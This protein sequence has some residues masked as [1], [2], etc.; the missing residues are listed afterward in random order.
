MDQRW[1][2]VESIF[3]RVVEADDERRAAILEEACAGDESLRVEVESLLARDRKAAN[4]METPAISLATGD[5]QSTAQSPTGARTSSAQSVELGQLVNHYRVVE[6]IGAGGMGVVYK[7]LDTRLD[8]AVALKFLPDELSHDPVAL[9]RFRREAKSASSLN[10]SNI[11]TIYDIGEYRGHS[12]IAMEFLDG[13]SLSAH[14]VG[15]PMDMD[16]VLPLAIE[17][18]DGLDAAHSAGIVHRD[19]KSANIFVT[20]RNHAK[21]LDFGLAKLL[22]RHAG[23]G[24]KDSGALTLTQTGTTLGT[25]SYMSP[26]QVRGKGVDAR[27]DLFSF[28]VVL[29]EMLTGRLPFAGEST[30]AIFDSILNR[31]PVPPIR[32]NPEIPIELEN[33]LGKCLEKD[34]D[35]RYQHASEIRTDLRRLKRLMESSGAILRPERLEP[36]SRFNMQLREIVAWALLI[37]CF[38]VVTWLLVL[39]TEQPHPSRRSFR[40]SL[41]PPRDSSFVQ[42]GFALSPNGRQVAFVASSVNGKNKLWLRA[43]TASSTQELNGTDGALFPFWS[44]DSRALGYFA[45]GKLKTIDIST[46]FVQIVCESAAAVGATWNSE[47]TIL[48]V[49]ANGGPMYRVRASGGT[50]EVVIKPA[51]GDG[52]RWPVF[53]PDNDHF[54]FFLARTPGS[55]ESK[56]A[57]TSGLYLGSLTSLTMKLLSTDIVNNVVVQAGRIY[58]VRDRSLLAQ[59]FDMAHMELTGKPEVIVAE[60]LEGDPAFS[61]YGFSVSD[62]GLVTF[63]SVADNAS[64]LSWFDREGRELQSIASDT[65]RDP[66]LSADGKLLAVSSDDGHNG[67]RF[68][69]TYDMV[70]GTSTRITSGGSDGFPVLSPDAKLVAFNDQFNMYVVPTDDSKSPERLDDGLE[71]DWSKNGRFLLYMKFPQENFQPQL[72]I[73]DFQTH[74]H[75]LY[76]E[77][78]AEAQFSP[79]GKW[80]AYTGASASGGTDYLASDI[81]VAPFPGPGGRLQVSTTS[82]AQPRWRADGR[83]L[84]YIDL[85]RNLVAVPIT[86][87]D[88]KLVPGAPKVLFRTRIFGTR[89]VLF[90]YSVSPDGKRFLINSLPPQGTAPL[91]VLSH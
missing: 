88:G 27:T 69:R 74:S 58:F 76:I 31:A 54:V 26:E 91:T 17:I 80:V 63:Q 36:S 9:D 60:E 48:F 22:P 66:D 35:L 19:I 72:H 24:S 52:Y 39:H 89:I 18:A 79:D 71:N 5:A 51:L 53:L 29:Y 62:D 70:R 8:R 65:F 12:Y 1:Q 56:G 55:V 23:A 4:F 41:L 45:E 83:E 67:K 59:A 40:L 3:Q 33:I 75:R 82:G 25:V 85:D 34:R 13:A 16:S 77:A 6:R 47:G 7:A 46:G 87:H 68:V 64:R 78:G 90:Q 14:I 2:T 10:H 44:P 84:Y 81:I 28:G 11:C 37:A 50:P 86:F 32:L 21:I 49:P 43:L 42:N 20:S 61:R 57:L 73:Y 38:A 30:G 15:K